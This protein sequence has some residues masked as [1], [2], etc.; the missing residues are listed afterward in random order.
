MKNLPITIIKMPPKGMKGLDNHPT[1]HLYL[2]G[3]FYGE[4]YFNMRGYVGY[5][6]SLNSENPSYETPM[7]LHIGEKAFSA[8]K[9][10]ITKLNKEWQEFVKYN[11]LSP[12][13][14]KRMNATNI[15]K[16]LQ[17]TSSFSQRIELNQ[18]YKTSMKEIED[19][20]CPS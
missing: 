15:L 9:K 4:I 5:L 12:I 14:I 6:P 20:L 11:P 13:Q 2:F 10:E 18:K 17:E 3:Y 19:S 7:P 16:E 1:Y 8:Y